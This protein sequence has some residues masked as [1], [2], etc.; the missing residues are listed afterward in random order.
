MANRYIT[1]LDEG[2]IEALRYGYENGKQHYFRIKCK[3]MLLSDEGKTIGQIA[4]FA[5]KTPRTIRN[6]MDAYEQHGIESF[7][8]EEGRGK[9]AILDSINEEQVN[10]VKK[11]VKE[12]YQNLKT[13]AA[14][15]SQ[16]LGLDVTHWMLKGFLKKNAI[17][18]GEES[19]R[20]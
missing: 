17:T 9:K 15:V 1:S 11:V 16:K 14:I 12:N 5:Q 13:A 3:S 7:V 19:E 8:V 18:L 6:W 10:L 2:Q 4:E 20:A